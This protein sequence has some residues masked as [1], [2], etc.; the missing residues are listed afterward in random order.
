MT[1]CKLKMIPHEHIYFQSECVD[2]YDTDEFNGY[3]SDNHLNQFLQN[4]PLRIDYK[5]E[6][7]FECS[8]STIPSIG[9]LIRI[10]TYNL[11]VLIQHIRD[12]ID[13]QPNRN[14]IIDDLYNSI[15]AWYD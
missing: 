3:M 6:L 11:G 12:C 8:E 10:E 5:T 14:K 7:L 4:I 9:C 1:N 13:S 15:I 2:A